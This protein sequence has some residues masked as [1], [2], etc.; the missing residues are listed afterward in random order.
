MGTLEEKAEKWVAKKAEEKIKD[1]PKEAGK[2]VTENV[3]GRV[4]T[5]FKDEKT[6]N[7]CKGLT[8]LYDIGESGVKTVGSGA[9][10]LGAGAAEVGTDGAATPVAAPVGAAAW[11]SFL[12]NSGQFLDNSQAFVRQEWTGKEVKTFEEEGKDA[13]GTWIKKKAKEEVDR[14]INEA[15]TSDF[16]HF[17]ELNPGATAQDYNQLQDA[18]DAFDAGQF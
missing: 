10:V 13:I 7:R 16:R 9:T 14:A 1:A 3:W 17:Q 5:M 8:R 4:C 15:A 2:K 18:Q 11:G 12:Y 6:Q